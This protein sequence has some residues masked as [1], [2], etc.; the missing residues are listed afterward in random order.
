[1]PC[2]A[3][4]V[5]ECNREL[6]KHLH[7]IRKLQIIL[8]FRKLVPKSPNVVTL[9]GWGKQTLF[10]YRTGVTGTG[11]ASRL[12][13]GEDGVKRVDFTSNAFPKISHDCDVRTESCAD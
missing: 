1:M 6:H 3:I 2:T 5:H 10:S 12:Q 4:Q 9:G 11:L 7:T 13:A 8:P